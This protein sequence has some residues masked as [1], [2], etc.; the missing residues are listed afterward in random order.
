MRIPH[1]T[2]PAYFPIH[3]PTSEPVFSEPIRHKARGRIVVYNMGDDLTG[4]LEEES[5]Q[6]VNPMST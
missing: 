1:G 3:Y 5:K 4:S 6:T 2:A